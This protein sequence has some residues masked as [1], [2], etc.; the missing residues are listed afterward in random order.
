[1][2]QRRITAGASDVERFEQPI[3]QVIRLIDR[4]R[5]VQLGS[6]GADVTE[7]H[8]HVPVQ[9]SRYREIHRLNIGIDQVRVVTREGLVPLRQGYRLQWLFSFDGQGGIRK[10]EGRRPADPFGV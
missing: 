4:N 5:A 9:G 8:D 1:I 6:F 10:G 2:E 3:G 7:V